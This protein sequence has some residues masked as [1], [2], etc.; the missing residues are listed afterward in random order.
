MGALAQGVTVGESADM[1]RGIF[2]T[3]SVVQD[4]LVLSVPLTMCMCRK[5]A[6]QDKS[7]RVRKAYNALRDD[8]DLVALF[9]LREKAKGSNSY[10]YV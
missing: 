10:I 5:T 1:G 4:D 2:A 7:K 8:E 3:K 6:L 9:I